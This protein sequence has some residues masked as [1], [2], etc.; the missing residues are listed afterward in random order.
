MTSTE[1]FIVFGPLI[2]L[3]MGMAIAL[4]VVDYLGWS[5]KL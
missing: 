1:L 5:T 3:S 4:I 2:A